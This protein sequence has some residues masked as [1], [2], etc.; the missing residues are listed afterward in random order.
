MNS[1]IIKTFDN[2]QFGNVRVAM[3]E[4]NEPIFCAADVCNAL[5]YA[6]G[7]DAISKHTEEGDVVKCDTPTSSGI[8][9]M[10]YVT[11]SGLYSLIFGS[12]L[13]SARHFKRWIVTDV[14][15]SIRKHGA[16]MTDETIEKVL[17]DPDLIISLATRLKES[18]ERCNQLEEENTHKTQVIEGLV[19]DIPL[20]DMRQRITQI[21]RKT[22]DPRGSYHLLY[23]EF[24]SKYH[25]NIYTRMNN[26]LY[27]KSAMDFIDDELDM[28]PQL[29][30]LTCKLFEN[31]YEALMKSW[32]KAARRADR[33]RNISNRKRL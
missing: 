4:N 15:P 8:Q 27:S 30:D 19:E 32:G 13:R 2:P 5:G 22:G 14:L 17:T 23:Q 25:M 12:K 26:I 7:R 3:T 9:Q 33:S 6:N 31:S 18:K 16:Y 29:Y 24:N 1:N 20:A 11:E 28:I 10:T 21:V